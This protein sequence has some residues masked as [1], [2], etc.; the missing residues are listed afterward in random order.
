MNQRKTPRSFS[1]R[2][3]ALVLSS[4]TLPQDPSSTQDTGDGFIQKNTGSFLKKPALLRS[5]I[6]VISIGCLLLILVLFHIPSKFWEQKS[7]VRWYVLSGVEVV[8][9]QIGSKTSMVSPEIGEALTQLALGMDPSFFA[10][11]PVNKMISVRDYPN[12]EAFRA[13]LFV[14]K[15]YKEIAI[16]LWDF[17][18]VPNTRLRNGFIIVIITLGMGLLLIML[19]RKKPKRG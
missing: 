17:K 5:G 16:N 3:R 10:Q 11:F 4:T 7:D 12:G 2:R 15:E 9:N 8:N 6:F 18:V 1:K 19:A 14:I 13:K